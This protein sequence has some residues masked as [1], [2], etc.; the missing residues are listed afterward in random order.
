MIKFTYQ[1]PVAL[2]ID[3]VEVLRE[4]GNLPHLLLR[5]ALRGGRFPQRALE[6]FARVVTDG[7]TVAAHL[8]DIDDD[9]GGLRAYF[10]TDLA[11]RGTLEVGYG[12]DVTVTVPLSRLELQA[13]KLDESRITVKFQRVTQRDPGLFRPRG[14]R[15]AGD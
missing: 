1:Q 2:Q 3:A 8:V 11:L 12:G 4:V 13:E 7:K 9:E 14:G 15:A 10:A 6:P 5:I